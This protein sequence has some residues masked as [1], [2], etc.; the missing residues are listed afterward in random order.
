MLEE[1]VAK[2]AALHANGQS[3]VQVSAFRRSRWE[4]A[5][6]YPDTIGVGRENAAGSRFVD[7]AG[8]SVRKRP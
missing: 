1:G 5:L 4:K 2:L 7:G 8:I 6:S 3:R